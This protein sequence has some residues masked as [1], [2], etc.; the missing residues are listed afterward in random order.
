MIPVAQAPVPL[1]FDAKV[2]HPGLRAIA[3]MVGKPSP[4]PR[5]AGKK[6]QQLVDK[7]GQPVTQEQ[8]IPA[9]A[10]PA[11]WREALPE[12]L[13]AYERR[14]AYLAMH[15]HHAT[16]NPTVDHVLPKSYAWNQVYEWSNYR[17]CAAIINSKKGALLTLV[18]PFSIGPGWFVLNLNTLQVERGGNAPQPE[19]ARIDATL[20]VLNHRLCVQE[21]E[22]YVRLYRLGPGAGGFDLQYLEHRAPF[23]AAELRR[24]G[25]LVRGDA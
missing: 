21:R 7:Q 12:M 14:C 19:W 22:E 20:P 4:Y 2:R 23:I 3:E 8:A 9:D 5:T 15:I 17:L 1:D 11:Y 18:D 16:G 25:Q 6:H 24:Q 13:V 10:F